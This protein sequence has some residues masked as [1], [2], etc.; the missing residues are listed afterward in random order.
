MT[1]L[2]LDLFYVGHTSVGVADWLAWTILGAV[3]LAVVAL[4]VDQ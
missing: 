1:T 2:A 4:L 3:V